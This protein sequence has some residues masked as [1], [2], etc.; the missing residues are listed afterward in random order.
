[1]EESYRK[2]WRVQKN[3]KVVFKRYKPVAL[4]EWKN[5][6]TSRQM[7]LLSVN[8]DSSKELNNG[9]APY[10]KSEEP[11]V[12]AASLCPGVRGLAPDGEK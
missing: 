1:M 10:G 2:W 8:G 3:K 12:N 7:R 4:L 9:Q 5:R 11:K 6:I